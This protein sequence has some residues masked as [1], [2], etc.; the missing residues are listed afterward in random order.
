MGHVHADLPSAYFPQIQVTILDLRC[1]GFVHWPAFARF[2]TFF[3]LAEPLSTTARSS[4]P[5][6]DLA[7]GSSPSPRLCRPWAIFGFGLDFM[8]AAAAG[9]V[10]RSL[11]APRHPRW[12]ANSTT[13]R[14]RDGHPPP[15]ESPPAPRATSMGSVNADQRWRGKKLEFRTQCGCPRPSQGT[16]WPGRELQRHLAGVEQKGRPA[17]SPGARTSGPRRCRELSGSASQHPRR[18]RSRP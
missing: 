2:S 12:L 6:I 7:A 16:A 4:I 15:H 18:S 3:Q 9:A 8:G 17:K 14:D 11:R 13:R 10:P 5:R 1:P